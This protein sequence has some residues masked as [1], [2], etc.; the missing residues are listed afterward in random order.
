MRK[1]LALVLVAAVPASLGVASATA[2]DASVQAAKTRT[3][4]IGDNFFSPKT[5]TVKKRTIVKWVWGTGDRTSTD[6]EHNVR[7]TKG[8]KFRSS[9]KTRGSFR[10]RITKTTSIVCDVHFTTMR[11]KIKVKK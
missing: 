4:R 6:F 11:M 3:V 7:G 9:V 5:I 1:L 10:K 2:D 8:N